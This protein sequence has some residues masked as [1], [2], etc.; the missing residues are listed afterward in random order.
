MA[1]AGKQYNHIIAFDVGKSTL[2]TATSA[3]GDATSEEIINTPA[4]VRRHLKRQIKHNTMADL[5]EMLVICEATGGYERHVLAIARELGLAC[6][7][8]HATSVR[9]FARYKGTHAK[10]DPID[11]A[12]LVDYARQTPRLRLYEPPTKAV[13][14][15]R[16]LS[17]RRTQIIAMIGAEECRIEHAID[18]MV[19]KSIKAIV[20]VLTREKESIEAQITKL[21][22]SEKQLTKA[23]KLMQSVT[24]I[25]ERTVQTVL[26]FVPEIGQLTR[27]QV[28]A[29]AG[30]APFAHDSGTTNKPRHI[31]AGRAVVRRCLYMAATVAV[32]HNHILKAFAEGL[33]RR[34]KPWKLVITAVMRKL[35]ITLN[36][37]MRDQEPWKHA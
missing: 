28:A 2:F 36:A 6:H 11:A 24:G 30:L 35:I 32:R 4:H 5:G 7:R 27:G 15:L 10:S 34:G 9:H 8:A 33:T 12:T 31:F 19:K 37:I 29:I 18:A 21:M 1:A 22:K 26:A 14:R 23:N 17:E 20:R 25:G 13:M 16:A 3:K